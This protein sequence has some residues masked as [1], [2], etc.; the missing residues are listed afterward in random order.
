M[1]LENERLA[2]QI[3]RAFRG[4]SWHGPSVLEIL[5]GVSAEEAAAHPIAGAHSIWEI[6][7]HM[8]GGYRLL[9]R[10]LRGEDAQLSAEEEWPAVPARSPDAWRESQRALEELNQQM[11]GAVRAFPADRLLERLG[12]EHAAYTQ[13]AGAPQHDLYHAGQIV[14][15]KK[16]LAASRG[17]A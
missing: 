2:D 17:A 5:A 1:S 7:L 6:V 15:L 14:M 13:F 9:L 8:A 3:D 11:Q 16:A 4:E 12:S 10:R